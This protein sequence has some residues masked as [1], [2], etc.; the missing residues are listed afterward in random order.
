MEEFEIT[1]EKVLFKTMY[2]LFE[3]IEDWQQ[4]VDAINT[5]RGYPN[6]LIDTENYIS[7]PLLSAEIKDE[8]EVVIEASKFVLPVMA[9]LQEFNPEL[10]IN[11]ILVENYSPLTI[12]NND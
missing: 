7:E 4:L 11:Y 9:D 8:N 12:T 1:E 6:E 10:F 5:V 3:N 2:I